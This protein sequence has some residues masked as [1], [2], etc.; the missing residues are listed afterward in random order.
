[1]FYSIFKFNILILKINLLNKNMS[2]IDVTINE[3]NLFT[4]INVIIFSIL[5]I[6]LGGFGL[7][8]N[9]IIFSRRSLRNQSS[10]FYFLSSSFFNLFVIFVIIPVRIV[11]EGFNI[12]L[13]NSNIIICKMEIYS[14]NV[15]RT[16]PCWLIVFACIDRYIHSSTNPN[17]RRI[18]SLKTAKLTIGLT[19]V[20]I[21]ILY[22]HMIIYYQIYNVPNQLG[23][24]VPG[25]YG[26]K[27]I[28]R[29]FKSI[30]FL[31]FYS[32]FPSLLM[33]IFGILT[34]INIR[35][36]RRVAQTIGQINRNNSRTDNRL[37]R[38]LIS[39][40][41]VIILSTLPF[42]IYQL[43]SALTVTIVKD[44]LRTSIE[45]LTN[46][47]TNVL[48]YFAHSTSFYMYTLT[49][50]IFR[51]EFFKIIRKSFNQNRNQ[52]QTIEIQSYR[53]STLPNNNQLIRPN[54]KTI[55]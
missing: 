6:I 23:N 16:I 4:T 48:T 17:I 22:I 32:L 54:D 49:G 50:T 24:I 55:K 15:L 29:T 35:Q 5:N 46:G 52:I 41:L 47:T 45:N 26:Q 11:S 10:S 12:D 53:I 44:S 13:A 2:S 8:F 9:I 31:T 18:S 33:F 36:Q 42:T 38:M 30:W 19:I 21:P 39:Q 25:C 34:L 27:G 51:K 40:V 20:F 43:Y 7:I 37:L 14:F 28:Y 3:I 1:M